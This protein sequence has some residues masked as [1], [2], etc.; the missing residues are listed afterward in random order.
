MAQRSNTLG[1]CSGITLRGRARF[2]SPSLH[3]CNTGIVIVEFKSYNCG[4][5]HQQRYHWLSSSMQPQGSS[6]L[7]VSPALANMSA[8]ISRSWLV[9]QMG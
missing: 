6:G 9:G 8:P 7:P 2:P 1:S 4:F 3:V 5:Y